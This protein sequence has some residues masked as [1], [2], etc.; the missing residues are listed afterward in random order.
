M[1]T[2]RKLLVTSLFALALLAT[3]MASTASAQTPDFSGSY[4]LDE[5]ASDDFFDAFEP[6]LEEMNP[7]KRALARRYLKKTDGPDTRLRLEQSAE[8]VTVQ[9]ED[10]PAVA[11]P[12]SGE[13]VS[14]E[15]DD[16]KTVHFSAGL[17]GEVLRVTMLTEGGPFRTD[18]R[19]LDDGRMEIRVRVE[20]EQLP[21]PVTYRLVYRAQ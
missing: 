10:R 17:R 20:N 2:L 6:A 19:M 4:V 16:G 11:I 14:R 7:I 15:G 9:G 1:Q 21:L 8:T 5:A 18:Y 13:R 3:G 12:L